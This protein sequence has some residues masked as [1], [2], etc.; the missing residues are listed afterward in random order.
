MLLFLIVLHLGNNSHGLT[1]FLSVE[2][3]SAGSRCGEKVK[4]L[5][6]S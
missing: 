4:G 1:V 3:T 2:N 5:R 6:K